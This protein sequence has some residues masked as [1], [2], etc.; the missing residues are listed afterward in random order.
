MLA[1]NSA[2]FSGGEKPRD[3]WLIGTEHEKFVYRVSDHRAP[4]YDEPGGIRDLL[5]GMTEF[6]W[7]PVVEIVDLTPSRG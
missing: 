7:S 1:P 5:N 6:G 2:T 4:S 3:S